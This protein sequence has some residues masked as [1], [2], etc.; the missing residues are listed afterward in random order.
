MDA[1][2][3]GMGLCA[4]DWKELRT[5]MMMQGSPR[6]LDDAPYTRNCILKPPKGHPPCT[7]RLAYLC[8]MVRLFSLYRYSTV[9]AITLHIDL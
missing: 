4:Q 5:E 8:F 3:V 1:V 2:C 7:P 6:P 9:P